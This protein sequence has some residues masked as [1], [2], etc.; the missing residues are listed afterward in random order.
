MADLTARS[1]EE[2]VAE[3]MRAAG[4][5]G[6]TGTFRTTVRALYNEEYID[7]CSLVD[8]QELKQDWSADMTADTVT[9]SDTPRILAATPVDLAEIRHAEWRDA[10]TT[11][12]QH[13]PL[14]IRTHEEF[15]RETQGQARAYTLGIP[16][17]I[18][19]RRLE[20]AR[21]DLMTSALVYEAVSDSTADDTGGSTPVSVTVRGFSDVTRRTPRVVTAALDGTTPVTLGTFYWIDMI[22]ISAVSTGIITV[23]Q[24]TGDVTVGQVMP[25][26]RSCKYTV[27]EFDKG[28]DRALTLQIQY[29][30]RPPLMYEAGDVP[31]YLPEKG[32]GLLVLGTMVRGGLYKK[33]S[34]LLAA[35]QIY[36]MRRA[37]FLSTV[38]ARGYAPSR[39]RM[40]R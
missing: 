25:G 18:A 32:H 5:P 40:A 23:R 35:E 27:F 24:D 2:G 19:P 39:I 26:E 1:F 20:G 11:P 15:I 4:S 22:G 14:K 21:R 37:E 29:Q 9:D 12:D 16:G 13:H 7:L 31:F 36:R 38:R 6:N 10:S 33:A 17:L 3:V 28:L 30:R 8:S 34:D